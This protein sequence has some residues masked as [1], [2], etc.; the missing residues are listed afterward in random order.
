MP[1]RLSFYDA[2]PRAADLREEVLA[3]LRR[4]PRAI[5]PKFFY[6]AEGSRLFDAITETPEYYPTRTEIGILK[7]NCAAIA[8]RV[9]A[10]CLLVEPGSG[11]CEKV[12]L[13]LEGL[14]P[15]AYVPLDISRDHLE[16]A[17]GRV[18]AEF[19]WLEVHA[20]CADFTQL[21]E[22]PFTAPDAPRVAF[23]PGSSIGNFDPAG[24]VAFLADVAALVGQGGNLLIGVDLK[25]DAAVLDAAYNDAQGVTAAFNLN[26][27]ARINRD[28]GADFDLATFRHHAFYNAALGRVEMH[29]LSQRRQTVHLAGESFDFEAGEG[30][31]TENSY[32]Y[33]IEE[34]Q[35]LA[36]RAAFEPAEVWTDPARLFSVHLLTVAER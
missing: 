3:G 5:P 23:F 25:K 6:D 19:P 21:L 9:G 1:S 34:F 35:A 15:V 8:A 4:R 20:A 32:K 13:L 10:A 33:S 22:L 28:L 27:L 24:A 29:L 11:S 7:A 36:R 26:L 30:I 14:R 17:S 16:L 31:H 18:A 2:H 12:R